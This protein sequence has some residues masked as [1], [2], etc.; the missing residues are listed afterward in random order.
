MIFG[1]RVLNFG[2]AI[3]MLKWRK[4][5]CKNEMKSPNALEYQIINILWQ[6]VLCDSNI[7]KYGK[8][9]DRPV[10]EFVKAVFDDYLL[11]NWEYRLQ[12]LYRITDRLAGLP[13]ELLPAEL[14]RAAMQDAVAIVNW[15]V[16][17]QDD[18]ILERIEFLK[19][20]KA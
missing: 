6:D 18:T 8:I 2:W 12:D 9:A 3:G 11:Q 16:V 20:S 4:P 13:C 17:A 7:E 5:I 19:N 14:F 15:D 10:T 1:D